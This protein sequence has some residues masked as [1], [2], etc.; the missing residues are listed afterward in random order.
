MLRAAAE[1]AVKI[2]DFLL[3]CSITTKHLI[4][5]MP[6]NIIFIRLKIN[7]ERRKD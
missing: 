5:L 4:N 2:L 3:F 1:A 6:N 7:R